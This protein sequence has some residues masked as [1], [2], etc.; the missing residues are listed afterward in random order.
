MPPLQHYQAFFKLSS[1]AL[2]IADLNLQ[3]VDS[4]LAWQVLFASNPGESIAS[5]LFSQE[6]ELPHL[7]AKLQNLKPESIHHL[8]NALDTATNPKIIEFS[9][10]R[11]DTSLFISAKDCTEQVRLAQQLSQLEPSLAPT[12]TLSSEYLHSALHSIQD[13]LFFKNA[14]GLYLGCNAAF[15]EFIG[16]TGQS[17]TGLSDYDLFPKANADFFTEC[18]QKVLEL[19]ICIRVEEWV[20]D[21]QG[22]KILLETALSPLL[23]SQGAQ[24]GILGISRDITHRKMQEEKWREGE[25]NFRSFFDSMND[26]VAI[27]S[28]DGKLIYA[29]PAT[30]QGLGYTLIEL[31]GIQLSSLLCEDSRELLSSTLPQL[32]MGSQTIDLKLQTQ[33]HQII[34]ASSQIWQG[35]WNGQHCIFVLAKDQ[36]RAI[37][38][39]ERFEHIFDNN[40]ALMAVSTLPDRI[41]SDVNETFV[42]TL[43]Y[44]RA[45]VIGKTSAELKLFPKAYQQER[46]AQLLTEQGHIFNQE[47]QVRCKDGTL[48]DGLFS[49][50]IIENFGKPYLLTVMIDHTQAK[51]AERNLL[52]LNKHLEESRNLAQNL[53]E[54][55]QKANIAKSEFLA[56]MS[57]E[58]RTPMNGIIGMTGL[59]LDTPLAEEQKRFAEIIRISGESLLN[60]INDILDF[61][62]I[63]AHRLDLEI[64]DFNLSQVMDDFAQSL[65]LKAEEKSLEFICDVEPDVP[66]YLRGDPGRLRQILMNFASN[67]IKFTHQGEVIVHVSCVERMDQAVEL[68][69]SIK[70]TGIGISQ[71][72][73]QYLFQ[74]FSQIDASNSRKFGGTGLGLAI[75]KQLAEMMGGSTGV[76]SELGQ[77]SEF[78]F[79]ARLDLQTHSRPLPH[80]S[81]QLLKAKV[82]ILDDN[83]TNRDLLLTRL[84]YFGMEAYACAQGTQALELLKDAQLKNQPFALALVDMQMPEMDGA[85]FAQKVCALPEL[86]QLRMIMLTS[87]SARGDAKHFES[88]GYSGYLSKPLRMEELKE[89]MGQVLQGERTQRPIATRFNASGPIACNFDPHSKIL[90]VEDNSFNQQ[91]AQGLLKKFGLRADVAANGLEA[92]S[93]L[94]QIPY[95]LVLMDVQMPI[96]DG[97]EAT[98]Q[99]RLGSHGVLN[100]QIPIV[101][102]TANAMQGDRELCLDSGMNDYITKPISRSELSQALEKWLKPIQD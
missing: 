102:M 2:A 78:W 21:P 28:L 30:L 92:L 29:N 95:D 53:A 93:A 27:S 1:D 88:L 84:R 14:Q 17:I 64:L 96:M 5:L 85:T 18:D 20:E 99:I 23:D 61:S 12:P 45:E 66:L 71:D 15:S 59:L 19:G 65:A 82:L 46:I 54:E 13:L 22:S 68:R 36:S 86:Q 87:M 57:H 55:A 16:K 81:A 39:Q 42:R 94:S 44:S 98:R 60:L 97:F 91:V 76:K 37:E 58:I 48:L 70:D 4:N 31:Q 52:E 75:S 33:T 51:T 89:M 74:K 90:L 77:G 83:Q 25:R 8:M 73:L 43:G 72:Q 24:L 40:P 10:Q 50:E 9:I 7:S 6:Q 80:S 41:L 62:K 100:S 79:S 69:F 67:A 49:G 26:M 11:H 35:F 38:V 56:T 47:L 34:P 32:H 63:E 3:L 101:A